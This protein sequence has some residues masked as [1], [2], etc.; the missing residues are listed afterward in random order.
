M[1]CPRRRVPTTELPAGGYYDIQYAK[2]I[3]DDEERSRLVKCK[4]RRTFAW[5]TPATFPT[6]VPGDR[7]FTAIC[8]PVVTDPTG[9]VVKCQNGFPC[10][11][12]INCE[13]HRKSLPLAANRF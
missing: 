1:S 8:G 3:L 6:L 13:H 7:V 12:S 10:L 11:E 9:S 2:A 5:G 4:A